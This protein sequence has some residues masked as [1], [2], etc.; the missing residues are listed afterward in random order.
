MAVKV[1]MLKLLQE[2]HGFAQIANRRP[3]P[4][5]PGL[6]LTQIREHGMQERLRRRKLSVVFDKQTQPAIPHQVKIN[7]VKPAP[8]PA[9]VLRAP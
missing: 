7:H 5:F 1:K 3:P 4:R 8:E 6:V 9:A 2:I